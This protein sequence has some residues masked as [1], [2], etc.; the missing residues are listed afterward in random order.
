MYSQQRQCKKWVLPG[1]EAVMRGT[2]DLL[3]ACE[4]HGWRC[5]MLRSW[6][7]CLFF[8]MFV[9][10]AIC[11]ALSDTVQWVGA[12]A[13]LDVQLIWYRSC[14]NKLF[15]SRMQGRRQGWMVCT[16]AGRQSVCRLWKSGILSKVGVSLLSFWEQHFV[17]ASHRFQMSI[18][19]MSCPKARMYSMYCLLPETNKC[20]W[21]TLIARS[22]G[23][24]SIFLVD[25]IQ[26][27]HRKILVSYVVV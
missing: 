1:G 19:Y 7:F 27:I 25:R 21:H 20:V 12:H 14:V 13:E 4:V 18:Y 6:T 26:L 22:C 10:H 16:Q 2:P 15:M 24:F 3:T 8:S 17:F 23:D 11:R 5:A 9:L